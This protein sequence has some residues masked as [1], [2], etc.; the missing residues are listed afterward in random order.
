MIYLELYVNMFI[1]CL[2]NNAEEQVDFTEQ[3]KDVK[4][5]KIPEEVTFNCELST[6][7]PVEWYHGDKQISRSDKYD[8]SSRG[9]R[10]QLVIHDVD[11]RDAGDYIAVCKGKKT[12]ASLTVEGTIDHNKLLL[13]NAEF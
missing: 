2:Y 13:Y 12:S 6:T 3:L 10:H 1:N 7:T 8:I 5:T 9:L 4:L 11:G